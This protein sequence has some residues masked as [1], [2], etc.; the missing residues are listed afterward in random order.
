MITE[1]ENKKAIAKFTDR[2]LTR[3]KS[4]YL[5]LIGSGIFIV[6]YAFAKVFVQLP[7]WGMFGPFYGMALYVLSM[8]LK[9]NWELIKTY[10]MDMDRGKLLL[11]LNEQTHFDE[12]MKMKL[13]KWVYPSTREVRMEI[14]LYLSEKVRN[15]ETLTKAEKDMAKRR[16]V[17]CPQQLLDSFNKA[18]LV[19]AL[20]YAHTNIHLLD[21]HLRDL[22]E[23]T[24]ENMANFDIKKE[25]DRCKKAKVAEVN[26]TIEHLK[27]KS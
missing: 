6:A 23:L 25:I 15:G 20:I 27:K 4:I 11:F 13:I 14:K 10:A 22:L 16:P 19:N 17:A 1:K 26:K 8:F 5:Y 24:D 21:D 9:K 2:R 7:L 18:M 12:S 3:A